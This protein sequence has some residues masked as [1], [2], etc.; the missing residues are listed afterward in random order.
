LLSAGQI[1]PARSRLGRHQPRR[2][3]PQ[4][5]A[6]PSPH[7]PAAHCLGDRLHFPLA[8][9][10]LRGCQAASHCQDRVLISPTHARLLPRPQPPLQRS[11]KP[12]RRNDEREHRHS[13]RVGRTGWRRAGY[14]GG[15]HRLLP[16]TCPIAAG[17]S[18]C[19]C[20][21]IQGNFARDVR[22]LLVGDRVHP[23][24]EPPS[25][26]TASCSWKRQEAPAATMLQPNFSSRIGEQAH[27]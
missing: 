6:D 3:H 7:P 5:R 9:V 26:P 22:H 19:T 15:D 18:G 11:P 17:R 23:P 24:A 2:L 21:V 8:I 25:R 4:R 14:V 27:G 13:D 1:R 12:S 10:L 16:R 20:V